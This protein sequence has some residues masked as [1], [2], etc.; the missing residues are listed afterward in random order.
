[1]DIQRGIIIVNILSNGIFLGFIL[2]SR[3]D[4]LKYIEYIIRILNNTSDEE[5]VQKHLPSILPLIIMVIVL[6]AMLLTNLSVVLLASLQILTLKPILIIH[7]LFLSN[8]VY[9]NWGLAKKT[10]K[11]T[12]NHTIKFDHELEGGLRDSIEQLSSS[13]KSLTSLECIGFIAYSFY[14]L[15]FVK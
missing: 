9:I 15:T 11:T 12:K 8:F 10:A 2:T 7:V 3:E 5:L 14:L 4:L 6:I 1:M 13:K